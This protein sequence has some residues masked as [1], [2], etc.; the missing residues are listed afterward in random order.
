MKNPAMMSRTKLCAPKP[1]MAANKEA[2]A[3]PGST[4]RRK[5]LKTKSATMMK[6]TY[7]RVV[8]TRVTAVSW[9]FMR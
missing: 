5:M 7:L 2:P 6:S 4:L 8:R 1:T 9:R 3:I